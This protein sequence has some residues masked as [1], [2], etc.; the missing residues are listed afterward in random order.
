MMIPLVLLLAAAVGVDDDK[1]VT[2]RARAAELQKAVDDAKAEFLKSVDGPCL[3]G[4][5]SHKDCRTPKE[6]EPKEEEQRAAIQKRALDAAADLK[7]VQEWIR[8]CEAVDLQV[9]V[10]EE[11][12]RHLAG[13]RER[14]IALIRKFDEKKAWRQDLEDWVAESEKAQREA[15]MAVI[16]LLTGPLGALSRDIE[17]SRQLQDRVSWAMDH[18][19]GAIER[20]SEAI[21]A[22]RRSGGSTLE[23]WSQWSYFNQMDNALRA[24]LKREAAAQEQWGLF[25]VLFENLGRAFKGLDTGIEVMDAK[26]HHGLKAAAIELLKAIG[27]AVGGIAVDYGLQALGTASKAA[28]GIQWGRFV[29]DYGLAGY[30]FYVSASFVHSINA[31]LDK[32]LEIQKTLRG[33]HEAAQKE[34]ND[35]RS[36]IEALKASRSKEVADLRQ[37]L[38]DVKLGADTRLKTYHGAR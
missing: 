38:R 36:E 7:R 35:V 23:A 16:D 9:Q 11:Q 18:T 6:C 14:L 27:E 5:A 1:L 28:V 17:K 25:V 3:C 21:A 37:A 20:A 2:Q 26:T 13:V 15:A 33:K 31:Q 29:A 22:A 34:L 12:A 8:L 19:R 32:D 24:L 10:R 30:R 4:A